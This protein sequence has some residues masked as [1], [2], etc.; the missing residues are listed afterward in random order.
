M[1]R[2]G[3]G[4]MEEEKVNKGSAHYRGTSFPHFQPCNESNG[5]SRERPRSRLFLFC[6]AVLFTDAFYSSQ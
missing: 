3:K 4:R 6:P 1:E 2:D 5:V